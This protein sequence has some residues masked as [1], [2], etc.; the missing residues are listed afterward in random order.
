MSETPETELGETSERKLGRSRRWPH[1]L[2][3]VLLVA[4]ALLTAW[5]VRLAQ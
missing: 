5:L 3:L 1:A 2:V 4:L